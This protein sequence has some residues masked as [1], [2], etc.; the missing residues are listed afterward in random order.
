MS[1]QINSTTVI[2]D[3]KNLTNVVNA[4]LSGTLTI[5]SSPSS[6]N[7]GEVLTSRGSSAPNWTTLS[8]LDTQFTAAGSITQGKAVI[9]NSTGTVSQSIISSSSFGSSTTF[10]AS[11]TKGSNSIYHPTAGKYLLFYTDNASTLGYVV[12]VTISGNTPTFGTPYQWS[13]STIN[14]TQIG[15]C[16]DSVTNQVIVGYVDNATS[17]AMLVTVAY[18]GGTFSKG[19]AVQ[20][21]TAHTSTNFCAVCYDKSV[22]AICITYQNSSTQY[23]SYATV[24]GTSVSWTNTATSVGSNNSGY[25]CSAV[26]CDALQINAIAYNDVGRGQLQSV[27]FTAGSPITMSSGVRYQITDAGG[28]SNGY[29]TG[30]R[31]IAWAN[32]IQRIIAI[33]DGGGNNG[34]YLMCGVYQYTPGN[35]YWAVGVASVVNTGAYYAGYQW[36]RSISYHSV[37]GYAVISWQLDTS[38]F[39]KIGISDSPVRTD[40]M[41]FS[42]S[43]QWQSTATDM[44]LVVTNDI[45]SKGI[46]VAWDS[47]NIAGNLN[48][49]CG[50]FTIP[51][52]DKRNQFI[53]L[54]QSTVTNGQTV[55]VRKS[56][57]VDTNQTGLVPGTRY[58]LSSSDGSTLTST[59]SGPNIGRALSTTAIQIT[60]APTVTPSVGQYLI[61]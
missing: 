6:G 1:I 49:T 27:K 61:W 33:Y 59:A 26:Y 17:R 30:A 8:N 4:T 20:N 44:S 50:I 35:F 47:G 13:A 7:T 52:P 10:N 48:G 39:G 41:N 56:F 37:T 16:W 12:D 60:G 36:H 53:G 23:A 19:T 11:L 21:P 54:A 15:L 3:S 57:G 25:G 24:S 5:G 42:S 9:L 55:V 51:N 31:T 38:G 32:D 2:D 58:Y 43:S 40:V 45:D 28:A 46:V 14:G 29:F 34:Y 18:S 22:S